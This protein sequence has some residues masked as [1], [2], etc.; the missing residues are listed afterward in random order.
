MI[1]QKVYPAAVARPRL[2]ERVVKNCF[3]SVP[4]MGATG[5]VGVAETERQW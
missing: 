5:M 4:V 1:Y 2:R 3:L